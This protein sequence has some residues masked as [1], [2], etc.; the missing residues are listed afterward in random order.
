MVSARSHYAENSDSFHEIN[1]ALFF[2]FFFFTSSARNEANEKVLLGFSSHTA[3][4]MI[5]QAEL[6]PHRRSSSSSSVKIGKTKAS[7]TTALSPTREPEKPRVS[8][9]L[10]PTLEARIA[11]ATPS[12]SRQYLIVRQFITGAQKRL[13]SFDIG[14]TFECFSDQDLHDVSL[15]YNI[16][17][18]QY[19]AAKSCWYVATLLE[20]ASHLSF[21]D[22]LHTYSD[23]V[24]SMV[25]TFVNATTQ[26]AAVQV[27]GGERIVREIIRVGRGWE[28]AKIVD[29]SSAY[30]DEL[31]NRCSLLW[32]HLSFL[33]NFSLASCAW[34]SI[35]SSAFISLLEGF[36]LVF[37]CSTEG[38]ALMSMDLAS[39]ASGI[40]PRA[41]KNNLEGVEFRC[42]PPL[43][44][45]LPRGMQ[46]VDAVVKAFYFGERDLMKWIEENR[47]S[48]RL[49]HCVGLIISSIGGRK[50]V[51]YVN[52]I[53]ESIK[54]YY[55]SADGKN[56]T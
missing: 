17:F 10:V 13:K 52:D 11:S 3:S 29:G 7:R 18:R 28:E 44:T 6:S 19:C 53:L 32:A 26:M 46:Y 34:E 39:F 38:R 47:A 33:E 49:E 4:E 45:S 43:I 31:S 20:C 50:S 2:F 55:Q 1:I 51:S 56:E 27:V 36:S 42:L 16:F 23:T 22:T 54:L 37:V 40:S 5:P 48:Y 15:L 9:D 8:R 41:V 24:A 21:S 14:A 25:S 35:I 12:D 30:I